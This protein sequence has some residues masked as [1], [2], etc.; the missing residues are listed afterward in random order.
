MEVFALRVRAKE[1]EA[2][3]I[4]VSAKTITGDLCAS[5]IRHAYSRDAIAFSRLQALYVLG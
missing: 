3:V 4:D 2:A 1:N 5:L